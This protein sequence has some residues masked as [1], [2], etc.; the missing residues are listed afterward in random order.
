MSDE[1]TEGQ[2]GGQNAPGAG[3]DAGADLDKSSDAGQGGGAPGQQEEFILGGGEHPLGGLSPEY[4]DHKAF[5]GMKGM[6]DVAKS[7]I[8]TQKML[9]EHRLKLPGEDA[10]QEDWDKFYAAIGR[11][12][13]AKDYE[14]NLPEGLPEGVVDAADLDVFRAAFHQRG[15]P[16]SM[17]SG[18]FEDYARHLGEKAQ[19]IQDKRTADFK[20]G[21]EKLE[22]DWRQ[23][24]IDPKAATELI[25]RAIEQH[26]GEPVKKWLKDTGEVNNPAMRQFLYNLVQYTGEHGSLTGGSRVDAATKEGAQREIESLKSDKSFQD[27]LHGRNGDAARKS[28]QSRWTDLNNLAAA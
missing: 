23:D 12:E 8:E 5:R 14:L 22:D 4:R 20:A 11:P 27:D 26:G 21:N 9:G 17:A 18:L 19:A 3:D 7:L 16:G 28:A 24:G 1:H 10:G 25:N 2:N 15:L 6:D 13:D